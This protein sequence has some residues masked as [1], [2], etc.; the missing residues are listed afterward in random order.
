MAYLCDNDPFRKPIGVSISDWLSSQAALPSAAERLIHAVVAVRA[1]GDAAPFMA[2]LEAVVP[3]TPPAAM[4]DASALLKLC[5]TCRL[6]AARALERRAVRRDE[7]VER[8][9][10]VEQRVEARRKVVER[11]QIG[12]DERRDARARVRRAVRV[13]S[14]G[15]GRLVVAAVSA[16]LR[17]GR[18][19]ASHI[20][21]CEFQSTINVVP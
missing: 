8:L 20:V 7:R 17:D 11:A 16:A 4:R 3:T 19:A 15:R 5:W 21:T 1:E 13:R 18:R 10:A 6:S 9:G 14:V 2:L 12:A